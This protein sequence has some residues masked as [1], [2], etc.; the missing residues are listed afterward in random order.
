[1]LKSLSPFA[2]KYVIQMLYIEEAVTTKSIEEWVLPDGL[3]KH[4]VAIDRL[5][6]LRIFSEAFDR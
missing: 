5:L 2:K 4:K 3:S 1:V 6:Q